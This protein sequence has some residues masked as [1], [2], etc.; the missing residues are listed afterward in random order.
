MEAI[1]RVGA[2]AHG[3]RSILFVAWAIAVRDLV[4]G[5]AGAREGMV[6]PLVG[7]VPGLWYGPGIWRGPGVPMGPGGLVCGDAWVVFCGLCHVCVVIVRCERVVDDQEA[8]G[9]VVASEGIVVIVVQGL[10][11]AW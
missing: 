6:F 1:A 5:L 3:S 2:L 9:E 10:R 4:P 7:L 8:E 11:P